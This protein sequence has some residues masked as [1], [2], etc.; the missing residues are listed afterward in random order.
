MYSSDTAQ[1]Q[2]KKVKGSQKV[3]NCCLK[4]G[5]NVILG[6]GQY[7]HQ[8]VDRNIVGV[9]LCTE[10]RWSLWLLLEAGCSS[11]HLLKG[12]LFWKTETSH[13]QRRTGES[14]G[15]KC[16]DMLHFTRLNNVDTNN[17]HCSQVQH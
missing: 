10:Q 12:Q 15:D 4:H 6:L 5:Q 16:M 2:V 8:F 14:K 17:T 1:I 11:L 7:E 13:T 9:L 3:F